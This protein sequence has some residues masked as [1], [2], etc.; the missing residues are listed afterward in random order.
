MRRTAALASLLLVAW[1]SAALAYVFPGD[2]APAFTKNQLAGTAP[3]P[4]STGSPV[5]LSQYSG[6][7]VV[8]FLLGW[9]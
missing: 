3:G 5:S 6:K 2:P 7:V 1:A 8:L 9:N 4:W